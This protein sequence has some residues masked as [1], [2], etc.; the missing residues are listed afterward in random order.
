MFNMSIT[1]NAWWSKNERRQRRSQQGCPR[2]SVSAHTPTKHRTHPWGEQEIACKATEANN[3]PRAGK[4]S[5]GNSQEKRRTVPNVTKG[6]HPLECLTFSWWKSPEH[7]RR[8]NEN[9]GCSLLQL[10]CQAVLWLQLLCLQKPTHIN[11]LHNQ[12]R[13]KLFICWQFQR[14]FHA[15]YQTIT[16]SHIKTRLWLPTNKMMEMHSP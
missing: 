14:P 5:A 2:G 10:P 8:K 15:S 9:T 16:K 11:P 13:K 6:G 4:G 3:R 12:G 7:K 1:F